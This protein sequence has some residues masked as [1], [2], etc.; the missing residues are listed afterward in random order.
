MCGLT[1]FLAPTAGCPIDMPRLAARMAATIRHRGPDDGGVWTDPDAGLALAHRRL[2]ILDLSPAGHQPM[3]SADGRWI[4]AYNGEVYNFAEVRSWVES[5]GPV[6]WRGHS[7]TEVVLEAIARFGVD[8]VLPRLAGMYALAV[9]DRAGRTLTLA[10]DPLGIKPL[11]YGVMAD[12]CLLFGSELKSLRVHPSWQPALDPQAVGDL[13]TLGF[14]PAPRTVYAHA[15]KLPPGHS[16]T[17]RAGC[18]PVLSA[19][20][21]LEQRALEGQ[22]APLALGDQAA[23]DALE[24]VLGDSVAAQMVSDVPLGAFLSGGVDSSTVVALMQARSSRPVKTFTIGYRERGFDESVHAAA[25]ARHLGTDHTELIVTAQDALAVVPDLAGIYDEPF[26]DSSQIPTLLVS[27]LTRAH[28]TVALSGDGGDELFAGYNRHV[29]GERISRAL[30]PV[31]APLRRL[32]ARFLRAVPEPA[33]DWMADLAHG[34]RMAGNKIHKLAGLLEA[35]DGG[36]LYR[37][38]LSVWPEGHRLVQGAQPFAMPQI[39]AGLRGVEQ[40]QLRDGLLYLPD[41]V[42]VKVDRA[43]MAASLEVRVPFLDHRVAEFAWRLPRS[44]RLRDGQG[45]WLVRNVLARH[46]PM[47]LIDR[48]KMGFAVP[49]AAWLRGPLRAWAEDLLSPQSLAATGLLQA[50]PIRSAWQA[51]L[52]GQGGLEQGLWAVLM[53]QE[54]VRRGHSRSSVAEL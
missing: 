31:P 40:M 41:D 16:M 52:Q 35:G 23:V 14:I 50:A 6:T 20:W 34:P 15:R 19:H 29:W 9:W 54:W 17:A 53:L 25:V 48:P 21:S 42:L 2:S 32:G 28:V 10:R 39:G 37:R 38:L 22:A 43:S 27:R 33:W 47:A 30:G 36:A 45:K 4:L 46:V 3:T 11:Y 5:R 7:D 44:F 13:L 26:A 49:I 1:G 8:A 12:G 18:A 24:T 51:H